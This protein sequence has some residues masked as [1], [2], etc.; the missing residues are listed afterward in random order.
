MNGEVL[1]IGSN[2]EVL[3]Y[4]ETEDWLEDYEGDK[5]TING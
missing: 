1:T 5:T 2:I 3:I 4:L